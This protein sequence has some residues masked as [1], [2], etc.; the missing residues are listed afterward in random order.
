MTNEPTVET[1][2]SETEQSTSTVPTSQVAKKCLDVIEAYRK[3]E[4]KSADKAF[5]TRE[6]QENSKCLNVFLMYL[7]MSYRQFKTIFIK[8]TPT[9]IKKGHS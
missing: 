1:P 3:S 2:N 5:S 8:K 4:R 7:I 9:W 6:H